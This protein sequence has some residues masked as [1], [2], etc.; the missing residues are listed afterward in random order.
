MD[1]LF[2]DT[3][4]PITTNIGFIAASPDAVSNAYLQWMKPIQEKRKVSLV[5]KQLQHGPLITLFESLLPLTS[6]ERRRFLF[7]PTKSQWTAFFDNGHKGADVFSALSYLAKSLGVRSCQITA[8]CEDPNNPPPR[9]PYGA[10]GVE[11]YEPVD[12][13]FL[14]YGRTVSLIDDDGQ[15]VFTQQGE[16][17]DFEDISLYKKSKARDRFSLEALDH[18]AQGLGI[19]A[20]DPEFYTVTAESPAFLIE[21]VGPAAAKLQEFNLQQARSL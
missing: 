20:F 21:K 8:V 4:R 1:L 9:G 18:F 15:W 6:V 3:F 7:V 17:F 10:L 16:P 12:T 5:R 19:K 13:N 2:G 11:I 14:N